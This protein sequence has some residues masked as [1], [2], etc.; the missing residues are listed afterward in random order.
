MYW[1]KCSFARWAAFSTINGEI[2]WLLYSWSHPGNTGWKLFQNR[3]PRLAEKVSVS[4]NYI[5]KIIKT[6]FCIIFTSAIIYGDIC[7]IAL[8]SSQGE[9]G[10][11]DMELWTMELTSVENYNKI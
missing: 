1:C 6:S 5:G 3:L 7:S 2:D 11:R 4:S 9:R 10:G 8:E